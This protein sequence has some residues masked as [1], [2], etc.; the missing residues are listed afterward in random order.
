MCAELCI[1]LCIQVPFVF[2]AMLSG[3]VH[4]TATHMQCVNMCLLD[5]VG[6]DAICM[7]AYK[8][9]ICA[10][11]CGSLVYR[12]HICTLQCD[13][14]GAYSGVNS[15][16]L[17]VPRHRDATRV[18]CV[19]CFPECL[20]IPTSASPCGRGGP[21]VTSA[22]VEAAEIDRPAHLPSWHCAQG[23]LGWARVHM[24]K[25]VPREMPMAQGP[26]Q[27]VCGLGMLPSEDGQ[28]RDTPLRPKTSRLIR[29]LWSKEEPV[30]GGQLCR[31]DR[32]SGTLLFEG[33]PARKGPNLGRKEVP[34]PLSPNPTSPLKPLKFCHLGDWGRMR[35]FH[36]SPGQC[37][38]EAE[39]K[40]PFSFPLSLPPSSS[41]HDI[42]CE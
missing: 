33:S 31:E 11:C 8:C 19:T 41:L 32:I 15:A 40:A 38:E 7:Q 20:S 6:S 39:R 29:W 26:G 35:G 16:M 23:Q 28:T 12:S 13:M 22:C 1:C 27:A 17:H 4:A 25:V 3:S 24:I 5:P 36:L 9:H 2:T 34:S 42:C 10:E 30:V 37:Q 14:F 21:H 18:Q